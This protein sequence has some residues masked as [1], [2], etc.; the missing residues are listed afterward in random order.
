[1]KRYNKFIILLFTA[2]II[3]SGCE[4]F[5]NLNSNP[6]STTTVPASMLARGIT[7]R[8]VKKGGGKNFINDALLMNHMVYNE[9]VNSIQYK[10]LDTKGLD[11]MVVL[12]DCKDMIDK[13][14]EAQV[15][16]YEGLASFAKAFNIYYTSLNL[17]EIPYSDAGFGETGVLKPKYDT[18]KD[19]MLGVLADLEHAYA[20]F[21]EAS[22]IAFEGD[23]IYG[24]DKDKWKKAT[25]ALQLKVLINLSKRS[26]DSDLNVKS[27]FASIVSSESLM[28]SNA[29]NFQLTYENKSGMRYPF[30]DMETNQ[31]KYAMHSSVLVDILKDF[32]DYRL[33]Y[34]AEP[35]RALADIPTDSYDA[36]IGLDPTAP[37]ADISKAH[38][39][40]MYSELNLR[41]TSKEHTEGEPLIHMGY[42]EQQLI[43]AEAAL[44]G[45]ITES[46]VTYYK[47]GIKANM[48]FTR[49][50]TPDSYAHGRVMTDEYIQSYLNNNKIQLNGQFEHD[51]NL[52]MTQKYIADYMQYSYESWYDYRR[53]GY[54][55][56]PINPETSQNSTGKDKIP[57][58]YRYDSREY[59]YN[60]ENLEEALGRQFGGSDDIND[61]MWILK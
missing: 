25:T 28:T 60:R 36:Y 1:M 13:A 38:G 34:Y 30:N 2:L 3:L 45:W 10:L 24:G 4:S 52:V 19:V 9:G 17:G 40:F 20:S 16:G 55:V 6:D 29:D 31:C 5:D 41:Y 46:A 54:P 42:G 33:F 22:A 37:F 15:K 50:V 14:P 56:Q 47:Q 43:L 35:A 48:E 51:L 53:T 59:N 61:V 58:R 8:M 39:E 11:N 57:V 23:P 7:L 18:Q 27:R 32:E 44:R 26:D 21:S 12:T 49:D